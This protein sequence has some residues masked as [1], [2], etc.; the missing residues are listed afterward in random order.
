MDT[1]VLVESPRS[2]RIKSAL[3]AL[4]LLS[5]ATA[6]LAISLVLW[7]RFN[8]DVPA[9]NWF[10]AVLFGFTTVGLVGAFA[11]SRASFKTLVL[12]IATGVAC[13]AVGFLWGPMGLFCGIVAGNLVTSLVAWR[14]RRASEP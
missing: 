9:I 11:L 3:T 1:Q 8:S 14:K 12:I 13:A 5:V 10:L 2:R 6:A 7:S 4:A